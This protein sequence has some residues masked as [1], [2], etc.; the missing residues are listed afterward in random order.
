MQLKHGFCPD[1]TC[2]RYTDT[3]LYDIVE[4]VAL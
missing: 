2:M 1:S 3:N 4:L